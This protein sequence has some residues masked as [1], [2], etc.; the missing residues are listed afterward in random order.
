MA[1]THVTVTAPEGRLTPVHTRDGIQPGGAQMVVQAGFVERVAYSQ[2][3]MR[4]INRGDLVLC[5]LN[6][7]SVASADLAA[8]PNELPGGRITLT[9]RPYSITVTKAQIENDPLNLNPE[10]LANSPRTGGKP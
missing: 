1:P 2:L 7:A 8:A 6:G 5:D 3:T 4:S 9:P 10:R